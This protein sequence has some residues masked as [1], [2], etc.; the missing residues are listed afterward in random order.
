MCPGRHCAHALNWCTTISSHRSLHCCLCPQ[1][2][3]GSPASDAGLQP[4]Y[5]DKAGNLIL[6]D[7]I[8]GLDGQPVNKLG[9]LLAALDAKRVGDQVQ[10]EVMRDGQRVAVGVKLGERVLGQGAE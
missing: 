1:A 7:V 4:T 9:D 8:V 3:P 10:L 5:R 6:G 2:P